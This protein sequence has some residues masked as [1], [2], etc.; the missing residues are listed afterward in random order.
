MRKI[1]LGVLAILLTIGMAGCMTKRPYLP[2]DALQRAMEEG[3]AVKIR[4]F[5]SLTGEVSGSLDNI[6][7]SALNDNDLAMTFE[8]A[9]DTIYFHRYDAVDATAGEVSPYYVFPKNRTGGTGTWILFQA[10]AY[11]RNSN[12][13]SIYR[14]ADCTDYDANVYYD[15]NC[16][17]TGSG[18]EDCDWILYVQINGAAVAAV[19]VDADA[20]VQFYFDSSPDADDLWAGP[21]MLVTAGEALAQWDIVYIRNDSGTAKAYKYDAND[22]TYRTNIPRG[23]AIAAIGS[24]STGYIGVGNGV[25]RNDGWSMTT[26]QDEGKRVYASTTAGGITLTKP[27]SI[28]D[29]NFVIGSVIEENVILFNFPDSEETEVKEVCFNI[30][31]ADTAVSTGDGVIAYT[32]PSFLNGYNLVNVVCS[33]YSQGVTGTTDVQFRRVRSGTPQDMLS[34]KITLA[35]EYYASDEG[36][37]GT[38]D[39]VA[40]G[41]QIYPDV[42]AVHSGTAPNGLSCVLEFQKP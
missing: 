22:A 4:G 35:A 31:D 24:G 15:V 7:E 21:K 10:F 12:P 19:T 25:A 29:S 26:N 20:G 42:D 37:N 6:D 3:E 2:P 38:Y 11:H 8:I 5:T 32:V 34:T 23:I 28:A 18:A 14:D 40:T 27:S 36:I 30:V 17:A 16:T 41:D 33:V 9:S 39:D 13:Q 1:L